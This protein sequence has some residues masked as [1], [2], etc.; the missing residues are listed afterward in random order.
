MSTQNPG[1][2]QQV[3]AGGEKRLCHWRG[4][5]SLLF[6]K[7]QANDLG[8]PEMDF[9]DSIRV[10]V[11]ANSK[12]INSLPQLWLAECRR[13]HGCTGYSKPSHRSS[14]P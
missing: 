2:F 1:R 6:G 11:I 13:C 12:P 3:P 5:L 4:L 10:E 7:P 8:D 9:L 14:K